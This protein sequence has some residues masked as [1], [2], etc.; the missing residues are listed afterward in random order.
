[1][2]TLEEKLEARQ[3]RRKDKGFTLIELLIVIAILGILAVVVVL[4]VGGT[5]TAA[6]NQACVADKQ[7]IKIAAEAYN[8][9][10]LAYPLTDAALLPFLQSASLSYS[11]EA[12]AAVVGPPAVPAGLATT[13]TT[14]H[15]N[16]KPG[17]PNNCL[18]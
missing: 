13:A 17:N 16:P 5:T 1:M 11:V 14:L 2:N 4:S 18:T 15:V 6:K 12:T 9:T 7:S 3:N 10:N 8:A